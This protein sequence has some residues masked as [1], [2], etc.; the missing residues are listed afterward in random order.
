MAKLGVIPA[1]MESE[2][3]SAPEARISPAPEVDLPTEKNVAVPEPAVQA[4]KVTA[5]ALAA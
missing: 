3:V 5:A 1:E 2:A 4:P